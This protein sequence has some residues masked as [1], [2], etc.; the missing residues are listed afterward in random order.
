MITLKYFEGHCSLGYHFHVHFSNPWHAFASHGLPAIAELLV[1]FTIFARLPPPASAA[2]CGPHPLHP[3][4]Y[5]TV[6][7]LPPPKKN[8]GRKHAKFGRFLQNPTLIA[9]ISGTDRHI[10]YLKKTPSTTTTSTLCEKKLGEL[11][12]TNNREPVVHIN[13][14]KWIFSGDYNSALK[15]R[16]P[17]KFFTRVRD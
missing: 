9:N 6:G 3:P 15:G 16:C 14:P 11:W 10:E 17:F 5:A 2:R 8:W 4:R 12:Y 1:F 13:P 7:G